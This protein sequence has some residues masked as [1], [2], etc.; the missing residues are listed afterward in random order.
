[1]TLA[2]PEHGDLRSSRGPGMNHLGCFEPG[3]HDTPSQS[4]AILV[5]A[6]ARRFRAMPSLSAE[7]NS[8]PSNLWSA[9]PQVRKSALGRY[10]F[11]YE[12]LRRDPIA[13]KPTPNINSVTPPLLPPLPLEHPPS[14]TAATP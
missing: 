3:T 14:S 6:G 1:M 4:P 2:P 13:N 8:L 5:V 10:I 9:S 7:L 12:R 11:R